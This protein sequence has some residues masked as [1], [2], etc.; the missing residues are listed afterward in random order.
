MIRQST[1][2]DVVIIIYGG[3]AK[4][5]QALRDLILTDTNFDQLLKKLLFVAQN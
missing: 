2:L 5:L 1:I 3:N 4:L